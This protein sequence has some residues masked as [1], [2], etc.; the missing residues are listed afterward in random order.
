MAKET[1]PKPILKEY[2]NDLTQQQWNDFIA[3]QLKISDYIK[4]NK[5]WIQ[6]L[7]KTNQ[8]RNEANKYTP[9]QII[10]VLEQN[11][12]EL[13]IGNKQ[14][15]KQRIRQELNDTKKILKEFKF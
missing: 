12:P 9:E 2:L 11:R 4:Q 5:F 1:T 3:G 10:Q 6:L 15:A 14:K 13:T 8:I 7:G